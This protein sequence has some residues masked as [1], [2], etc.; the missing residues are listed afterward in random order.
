M[1]TDE[2]PRGNGALADQNGRSLTSSVPPVGATV[3]TQLDRV[4]WQLL[5]GSLELH[6]L[7]P[8]L[9]GWYMAGYINGSQTANQHRI[10]RLT[11]ERDLFYFLFANP[12]K[13]PGDYYT[14]QTNA[15]WE[16]AV[17]A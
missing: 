6:H 8:A 15:L 1:I 9:Q 4:L 2:T 7:T 12:G 17:S 10:D 3:E 16:E 5:S 11:Y 13:K 14:H